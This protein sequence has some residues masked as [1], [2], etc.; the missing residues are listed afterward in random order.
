MENCRLWVR[1]R[2]KKAQKSGHEREISVKG[3]TLKVEDWD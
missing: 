1:M 2:D 3:E